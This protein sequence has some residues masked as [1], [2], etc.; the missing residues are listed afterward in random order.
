MGGE[1]GG[2]VDMASKKAMVHG[3]GMGGGRLKGRV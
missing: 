3:V 2:G 1:G